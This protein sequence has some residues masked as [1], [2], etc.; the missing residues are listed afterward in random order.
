[1]NDEQ[2]IEYLRARG[3]AE[4]EPAL[5]ARIIAAVDEAPVVRSPFAIILPAAAL[6]GAVALIVALAV[7][8]V[9]TLGVF[10]PGLQGAVGASIGFAVV[11][12]SIVV[13]TTPSATP[14]AS[15]SLSSASGLTIRRW[16]SAD[17][18]LPGLARL[19]PG[20]HSAGQRCV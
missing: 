8:I 15:N 16:I 9:L 20:P 3:R 13:L 7:F 5:V 12:L 6:V 1:M 18:V 17:M 2:V 11:M 19:P 4:P 10:S 14:A